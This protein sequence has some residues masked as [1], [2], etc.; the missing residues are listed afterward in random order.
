K[1]HTDSQFDA[2]LGW[3]S[4]DWLRSIT[5]LPIILKG[6]LHPDDA[7]E[8]LNRGVSAIVVSNHGGRQLD[9]AIAPLD[10][11]PSIANVIQGK[12]PLIVDGGVRSGEDIFKA[13]A[14][15][16]SAV[17][18]ARPV[19]WALAVGGEPV[20]TSLFKKLQDE[21]ELTMRL[22]GCHSLDIIKER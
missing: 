7:E 12:I 9:S 3:D 1:E 2:D 20:L 18:I 15:G 17:M 21:L 4:I 10:A 6:I 22:A 16:A 13:I 8:A 5:K 11:L 14:L 19:M